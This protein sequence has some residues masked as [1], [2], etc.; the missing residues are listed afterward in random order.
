MAQQVMVLAGQALGTE[1]VQGLG[2][3]WKIGL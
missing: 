1:L 2:S 3:V